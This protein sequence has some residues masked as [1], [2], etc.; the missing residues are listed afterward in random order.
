MRT[1]ILTL[2]LA[3]ALT[4][5]AVPPPAPDRALQGSVGR[6]QQDQEALAER[7]QRLQDNLLLMEARLKD[8]QRHIEE[9]RQTLAAQKVSADGEMTATAAQEPPT[10]TAGTVTGSPAELYRQAFADYASGRF[11]RSISGFESFLS[12]HPENDY[13]SNAQYWLGEC[14]Y[15][16]QRYERAAEEFGKLVERHPQGSKAPEALLKMAS[17]LLRA[18]RPEQA[19]M[20]LQALRERYPESAAARKSLEQEEFSNILQE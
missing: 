3:T 10:V 4:A 8:Q 15:S 1:S 12:R 5:C 9:M 19:T 6:L 18:D 14:Y 2:L 17:A 11:Q 16:L 20:A 13:A 7:L